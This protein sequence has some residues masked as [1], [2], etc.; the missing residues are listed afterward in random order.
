M[1]S[2]PDNREVECCRFRQ[3][4]GHL[5]GVSLCECYQPYKSKSFCEQPGIWWY[6]VLKLCIFSGLLSA[7]DYSAVSSHPQRW[8]SSLGATL[9]LFA[10]ATPA[11]ATS[12]EIKVILEVCH[13]FGCREQTTVE[14]NSKEWSSVTALFDAADSREE[15][16]QIKFALGY[17]EYLTGLYAPLG[18]D[19]AGNVQPEMN[20]G[21]RDR[22]G[23]LDCI[24]EAVNTT[25]FLQLFEKTG[26][27][28]YHRVLRPAYRRSF[29]VQHWAGHVEDVSS[30]ERYVY[31]S[32]FKDNG[33]PPL[34]VTS[35][36]W[37]D[38]SYRSSRRPSSRTS[39][40]FGSVGQNR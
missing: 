40:A 20:N 36:R 35:K 22:S 7:R 34:L 24:D 19:L 4:Y 11:S 12:R 9:L 3:R 21:Q 31:D 16:G 38:L 39:N 23:Q 32:W 30:G 26:L 1:D 28:R 2:C 17:M 5:R 15:R 18:R 37:H 14:I 6:N 29:L 13:G 27:L 25:R 8:L 33:Q 10:L